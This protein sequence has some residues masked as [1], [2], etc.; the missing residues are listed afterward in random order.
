LFLGAFPN[1]KV[2]CV[3]SSPVWIIGEGA[4][5]IDVGINQA[6]ILFKGKRIRFFP[7]GCDTGRSLMGKLGNKSTLQAKLM[8]R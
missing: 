5:Y 3:F 4:T 6:S 1:K 7:F 2:F 8:E